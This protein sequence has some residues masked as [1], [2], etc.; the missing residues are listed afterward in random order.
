MVIYLVVLNETCLKQTLTVVNVVNLLT[1]CQ[2][3]TGIIKNNINNKS[4]TEL[5]CDYDQ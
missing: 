4:D 5:G 2:S 3:W 1:Q